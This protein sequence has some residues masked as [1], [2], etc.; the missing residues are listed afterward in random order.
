VKTLCD[1]CRKEAEYNGWTNFATWGAKLIMDNDSGLWDLVRDLAREHRDNSADLQDALRSL[2]E[3]LCGLEDGL[4]VPRPSLM[5][6]Q[7]LGAALCEVNWRE[8]AESLLQDLAD[9]E[10]EEDN[11]EGA[12]S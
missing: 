4:G 5:A 3:E 8:I 11:G 12:T 7:L 2:T 6:A 9:E 1:E 10:P